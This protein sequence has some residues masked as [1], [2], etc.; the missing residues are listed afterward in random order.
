MCS[1]RKVDWIWVEERTGAWEGGD[2]D[3][4]PNDNEAT[5]GGREGGLGR[6]LGGC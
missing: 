4:S 6:D 3:S 5:E 1:P 2:M